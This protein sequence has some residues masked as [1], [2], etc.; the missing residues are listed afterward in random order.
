MKTLKNY[1]IP[2]VLIFCIVVVGGTTYIRKFPLFPDKSSDSASQKSQNT[3]SVS[4]PLQISAMRE[5]AY[6]GSDIVIEETLPS[7]AYRRYI[8]SYTSDGLKTYGLLTVPGGDPPVGGWPVIIF[9]HGYIP[10]EQYRTTERY[11]DYVDAFA[12][13]GYIVFKPD[14]RGHGNSEGKPEGAYYSPAYTIDVLNAV[15]SI[16]RYTDANPNEIGMWGH[17]LGG[18]IT[19]RAMVISK[20]IKAGV[21]WGGVVGTYEELLTKWRRSTPWAPSDRE[22]A[23]HITSI[24]QRLLTTYGSPE[25][26]PDFW[27]SIDPRFYLSDISGPLQL[28]QGLSDTEVP[29]LFSESLTNDLEKIGKPVEYYTY[30][31]TDHNISGPSFAL[32]IERSIEFFNKYLKGEM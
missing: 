11:V 14:Y 29:P 23:G 1:A 28:H 26:N 19:L 9:N 7:G 8:A 5:R 12:R 10:P 13:S 24:R 31:G 27:H 25:Q 4:F 22:I 2:L 30:E 17:S 6:P 20:D 16:E 32:A 21:I 18:N 15:A 3:E